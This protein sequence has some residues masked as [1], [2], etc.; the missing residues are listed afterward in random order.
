[1]Q[2]S[3]VLADKSLHDLPFKI[4]T[5]G[6]GQIVMSPV[7]NRHGIVRSKIGT[8]LTNLKPDGETILAC[9]IETLDGVKVTDIAWAS[10]GF[11]A[12]QGDRI[13]Y[14]NSPEVCVEIRSPSDSDIEMMEKKSLYFEQGALEVWTCNLNGNVRFFNAES[15]IERSRLFS[16]FPKLVP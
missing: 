2:W 4:E 12:I 8:M 13:A 14:A 6:Y 15:E 10:S 9:S 11:L 3:E 16:E 7:S 1:M 5:N